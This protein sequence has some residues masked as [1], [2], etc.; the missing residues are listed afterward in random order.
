MVVE[1]L[2]FTQNDSTVVATAGASPR[3][4]VKKIGPQETAGNFGS[5]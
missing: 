3:P 5:E 4:K 2:R 1:I